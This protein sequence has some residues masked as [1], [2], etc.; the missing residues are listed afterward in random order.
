MA[1]II[2]S[3]KS[4]AFRYDFATDGGG[5]GF[6]PMGVYLPANSIVKNGAVLGITNVTS[7]TGAAQISIG[8]A[9]LPL[10]LVGATS[11]ASYGA[12]LV[13]GG[14]LLSTTTPRYVSSM[15]QI[16]ITISVENLTGGSFVYECSFTN[17]AI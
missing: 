6:I 14:Q 3:T 1:K 12:G 10:N 8:W 7:G 15:V 2:T 4:V 5:V 11:I 13:I 16:G 9:A 17:Y